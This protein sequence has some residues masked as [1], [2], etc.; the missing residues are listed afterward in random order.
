[1]K[2][3]RP[4]YI[5]IKSSELHMLYSVNFVACSIYNYMHGLL[6]DIATAAIIIIA[7]VGWF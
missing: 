7:T 1:M 4:Q 2:V 3:F 6:Y 5:F